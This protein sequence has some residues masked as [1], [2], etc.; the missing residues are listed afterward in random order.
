M[1]A[2]DPDLPHSQP[3]LRPGCRP[4]STM[5]WWALS[6]EKNFVA[7]R[8]FGVILDSP[9]RVCGE[10]KT[11]LPVLTLFSSPSLTLTA[12]HFELPSILHCNILVATCIVLNNPHKLYFQILV[13]LLA[14][15]KLPPPEHSLVQPRNLL[16]P[17]LLSVAH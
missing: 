5:K 11:V 8:A 14:F 1:L 15:A 6:Q 7:W 17:F 4:T 12:L 9:R 13:P 16:E 10:N 2:H 3:G